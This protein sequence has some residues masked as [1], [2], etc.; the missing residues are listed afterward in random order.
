MSVKRLTRRTV[1]LIAEHTIPIAEDNKHCNLKVL[2]RVM[3]ICE[4]IFNCEYK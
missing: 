4:A 3:M 1:N 2:L